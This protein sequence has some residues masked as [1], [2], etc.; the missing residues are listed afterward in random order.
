MP[1]QVQ[2]FRDIQLA[3]VAV[4][5]FHNPLCGIALIV[6]VEIEFFFNV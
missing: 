2:L 4:K 3:F 6:H 5:E 1:H